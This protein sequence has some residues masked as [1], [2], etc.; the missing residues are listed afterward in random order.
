MNTVGHYVGQTVSFLLR[1]DL[2]KGEVG[3]II[4]MNNDCAVIEYVT[5]GRAAWCTSSLLD[6]FAGDL[7]EGGMT[8]IEL[9]VAVRKSLRGDPRH[10]IDAAIG[11]LRNGPHAEDATIRAALHALDKA[12]EEAKR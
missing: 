12:R 5:N 3:R 9:G 7:R 8:S 10:H 1:D 11:H 6:M 2:G 4:A